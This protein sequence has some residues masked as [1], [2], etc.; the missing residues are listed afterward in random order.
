MSTSGLLGNH[1]ISVHCF[2]CWDNLIF[3]HLM[4][5]GSHEGCITIT[6]DRCKDFRKDNKQKYVSKVKGVLI[7][8]G[9]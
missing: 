9:Y 3:N 5:A 8:Y 7:I 2:M 6:K 1:C 4:A